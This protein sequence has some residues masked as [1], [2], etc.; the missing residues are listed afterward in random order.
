MLRFECT[1]F[2]TELT[3]ATRQSG[4]VEAIIVRKPFIDPEKE[5]PR[6]DVRATAG[7]KTTSPT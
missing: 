1:E 7:A 4:R 6:Q 2:G 5:V 3:V